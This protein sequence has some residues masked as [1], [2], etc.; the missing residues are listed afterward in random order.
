MGSSPCQGYPPGS[1]QYEQEKQQR[2]VFNDI[3]INSKD[4]IL[5]MKSVWM[6]ENILEHGLYMDILSLKHLKEKTMTWSICS[7]NT[8]YSKGLLYR[9]NVFCMLPI[10][11]YAMQRRFE[12]GLSNTFLNFS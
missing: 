6:V 1:L 12:I 3:G 2:W 11:S 7:V 10:I 4:K 9:R 5:S 8:I